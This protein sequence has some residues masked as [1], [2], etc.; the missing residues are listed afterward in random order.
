M[1]ET[2][3]CHSVCSTYDEATSYRHAYESIGN[4]LSVNLIEVAGQVI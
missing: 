4:D 1:T 3:F 2:S